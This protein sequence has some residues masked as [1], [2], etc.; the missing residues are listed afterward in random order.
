MRAAFP[1]HYAG[2]SA[3][4][5]NEMTKYQ[6]KSN[7]NIEWLGIL[8]IF[9][10]LSLQAQI[11]PDGSTPFALLENV[12]IRGAVGDLITEGAPVN[13]ALFH[14][15]Q[16]FNIA[17]NQRVYFDNPTGI[18]NILTRVTGGNQS[19]IFG[20]LGVNGAANLYLSNEQG[21][22]FGKNVQLDVE[23]SFVATTGNIDLG[24]GQFFGKDTNI[25]NSILNIQVPLGLQYGSAQT[26]KITN[27]GKLEAAQDLILSAKNLDLEGQIFAGKNIRLLGSESVKIRDT[28]SDP[29]IAFSGE[30]LL[31]QGNQN[32]DIFAL[33]HA[34]SGLFSAGEMTLR[35]ES[36]IGGDSHYWSGGNFQIETLD[37]SLGGFYSPNDPII[38]SLGDVSFYRYKGASLHILAAGSVTVPNYIWVTSPDL[39][40]SIT[41]VT[42]P[43]LSQL[44]LSN[45]DIQQV[46]GSQYL[47]IDI[48]AGMKPEAI[49]FPIGLN[50]SNGTFYNS[51]LSIISPG[52]SPVVT[53]AD[54][55]IRNAFTSSVGGSGGRIFI[56]NQY[57]PN[58]ALSGDINITRTLDSGDA[59]GGGVIVLD[60]KGNINISNVGLNALGT[61]VNS[62][63]GEIKLLAAN[64][65]SL[66]GSSTI[67][68]RAGDKGNIFLS[69]NNL[70]LQE[71]STI[72][73]GINTGLGNTKSQAGDIDIN[74]KG[75]IQISDPGTF[76]SN[77]V[78]Q[79]A[80]GNGGDLNIQAKNLYSF[81]SGQYF[82]G[83]FS[84]GDAGDI[85]LKIAEDI[86]LDGGDP[87]RTFTSGIFNQVSIDGRGNVGDINIDAK[88]LFTKNG[89]VIE[90][91]I[92]GKGDLGKININVDNLIL[93]EGSPDFVNLS[94]IKNRNF[95]QFITGKGAININANNVSLSQG[96]VISTTTRG[97]SSA[98]NISINAKESISIKGVFRNNSNLDLT[99]GI[100]S[101][102]YSTANSLS[103]NGQGDGG[104]ID[105]KTPFLIL[106]DGGIILVGTR[107]SG[108]AGSIAIKANEIIVSG[109]GI[110]GQTSGI[111]APTEKIATGLGGNIE[112]LT[113]S[114]TLSKGGNISVA[115][116]NT[117]NA[118]TIDIEANF[119]NLIDGGQIIS[120]TERSSGNSGQ[121]TL[122]VFEKLLIQGE[123]SEF[124]NRPSPNPL[125][126][127]SDEGK[128]SGIFS[129]T[130]VGSSGNGGSIFIQ[131]KDLDLRDFGII[132]AASEGIG[133]AG[134]VVINVDQ[135]LQIV[136]A[137]I[138]TSSRQ[139]AGGLININAESIRLWGDSDITTSVL[140]GDGG[141]GNI[142]LRADSVLAFGDSDILAFARDGKGGNIFLITPAFFGENYQ[143]A[144]RGTDPETLDLNGRVDINASGAV[145]GLIRTPDV[146]FI[147]NN[148]SDL[149]DDLADSGTLLSRSCLV[150]NSG[151]KG[152]FLITGS[153]GL[154][155]R[156]GD[157]PIS[158]YFLEDIDSAEPT[159]A[160]SWDYGDPIEEAT[161]I[162]EFDGRLVMMQQCQ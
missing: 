61:D 46:D 28:E 85:N 9:C 58:D 86:I 87:I 17:E 16:D 121:I 162:Y 39:N 117:S 161:G 93:A 113:N 65:I 44:Q 48:R 158:Y 141:G 128:K 42:T 55:N 92:V 80:T 136:N 3:S 72:K 82:A 4:E 160:N 40:E 75:T 145:N 63:G 106:E 155:V 139:A 130:R 5:C 116:R 88:N 120:T 156:P 54:I 123:D 60:S 144:P 91:Y 129:N 15:L 143:P 1:V 110:N 35:S 76:I 119:V 89:G 137:N 152:Q 70:F 133:N 109:V 154:P 131:S 50:G 14:S 24:D 29:F 25:P 68:V 67:N 105:I 41:P 96:G 31:V 2:T 150:A 45:G 73:A 34:D 114:I 56:T 22:I 57:Q 118:G 142:L 37:G 148:L 84:Q 33:N 78:L 12:E 43:I 151:S 27:R 107:S 98:G 7:L 146:S 49:G 124:D 127:I 53:N 103:P 79:N 71:S 122:E 47:T 8:G 10:P 19:Q 134:Q 138:Q 135:T 36:E 30:N 23:G 104:N 62:I 115:T 132:S 159:F 83:T 157:I 21:F 6:R 149:P 77:A 81:D 69:G 51:A 66:D 32:I 99:F 108:N 74:L 102:L 125:D 153:G 18:E 147:D 101:G 52:I 112:I 126:D 26:G 38:R 94:G 97:A 64:N 11:I 20:T 100:S 111:L 13:N 59:L 90:G 140:S 95:S